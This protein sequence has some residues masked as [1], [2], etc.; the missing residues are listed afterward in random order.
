MT[1]ARFLV[2]FDDICPTMNWDVWASVEALLSRFNVSPILAVVP[3]NRD[4]QLVVSDAR[5]DF[6]LRVREWQSRGWTIGLHGWQHVYRSKHSGIIGINARSEFSGFPAEEQERWISSGLEIFQRQGVRADCWIAP[7][8]SFDWE[9]LRIL[10]SQK[11]TVVSDGYFFRPVTWRGS[12]WIP[13][14][15]WRFRAMPGGLW[16]VCFHHNSF[17]PRDIDRLAHD[18]DRFR[19]SITDL[20]SVMAGTVVTCTPLDRSFA[21][22][23]RNA[24]RVKRVV[25]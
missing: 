11:I 15:L 16:T 19:E 6:W 9:T 7:G 20:K 1:G 18:F 24:L 4:A 5:Q 8:H 23:W 22:F 13:Q 10:R 21:F 17:V 2:R 12:T 25:A 3:D 14:Q